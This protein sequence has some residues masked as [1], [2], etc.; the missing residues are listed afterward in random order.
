MVVERFHFHKRDQAPKGI[1]H[2]LR[3]WSSQRTIK[4]A[5]KN[6]QAMK[7]VSTLPVGKVE[8]T[9]QS[10]QSQ[11]SVIPVRSRPC[12]RFW[13]IGHK[14]YD[15]RHKETICHKYG[16][17]GRHLGRVCRGTG[18]SNHGNSRGSRSSQC[19]Q[20]QWADTPPPIGSD[21][22]WSGDEVFQLNSVVATTRT[23]RVN[24]QLSG[25]ELPMEI[26]TGVAVSLIS[27][28]T[29][30][31]VFPKTPLSKPALCMRTYM[32]EPIVV[33]GQM[34]VEVK[35]QDYVGRHDLHVVEGNEPSLLGRDWLN[36]IQQNWVNIRAVRTQEDRF[37]ID[38]LMQ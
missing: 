21:S 32:E 4:E 10:D 37:T 20:A 13:G 14:G 1:S 29:K 2:Q 6:A 34:R 5:H 7:A 36:H 38:Q 23:Y 11:N 15:C 19:K 30:R 27:L 22:D 26:D 35:Y 28:T 9:L 31:R 18:R 3:R 12:H 24:L 8:K 33:T 25:Q 17:R 16:K